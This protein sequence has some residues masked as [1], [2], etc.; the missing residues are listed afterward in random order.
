MRHP[1]L[2][3][4]CALL[5]A[6][7][8]QGAAQTQV[9]LRTQSKSI[10]FSA[11]A[12]T[13]PFKTGT[14]LPL[15][16]S[17]GD[18]FFKTDAVAGRNV[19]VC[20]APNVWSPLG[21]SGGV[22]SV[23]LSL[24]AEY[25]VS[26][27]PVT[28]SG[29]FSVTKTNQPANT[30]YA[31]PASGG[32]GAPT[33]R[34]LSAAEIPNLSSTYQATSEKNAP[35]GY[36]GVSST[37]KLT[38]SQ[39]SEVW[40]LGDL[41]DASGKHGSA[42]SVQMFGGG[43]TNAGE[44]ATFDASGNLISTGTPCGSGSGGTA[45]HATVFTTQSSV[46]IAGSSHQ[47]GTA[48]LIVECY[49]GGTPARKIEPDS[50][51]VN[52]ASYDVT[53]AFT[54][55]QSGKCVVNGSGGSGIT[56]VGGDISGSASSAT[57][58]A[59]Q[60]RPVSSAAPAAGQGLIWDDVLNQWKPGAVVASQQTELRVTYKNT[61]TLAIGEDC[62]PST[63]CNVRFSDRIYTFTTGATVTI[64]SG[65]GTAYLYVTPEGALTVGHSLSLTCSS[66]S[67]AA[68][69][70][71]FPPDSLPLATWSA[72]SGVWESTGGSDRRSF[73]SATAMA[74]GT[75]IVISASAG[76]TTVAVDTAVTGLRVAPP[77][78]SASACATGEWASDASYF[79]TCVATNT[80]R[81]A[82]VASW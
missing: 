73:L 75:G 30:V 79:Y 20:S 60:N 77:L 5:L 43:S 39:G 59:I 27:S 81:R 4:S 15:T 55:P 68:G 13:K 36:A 57:V 58:V 25:S 51:T 24:P 37:G 61:A 70:N 3:Q 6:M 74:A 72:T 8:W 31:G 67:L 71:Y 10:D 50:V 14:A 35:G 21:S 11:A 19:Y 78:A 76:R 69:T 82:S 28:E 62:T 44:C 23:G 65:T 33:F 64:A 46:T 7:N 48:N 53:V 45:N 22:T 2:L 1:R 18:A 47:M 29:T 80:W 63:P 41:T 16:C 54:Q 26:G 17:A 52:P 38:V 42:S 49:D 56:T 9:D 66:C 34:A 32:A 40:S 12:S